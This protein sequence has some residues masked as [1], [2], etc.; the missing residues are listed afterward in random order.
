[1]GEIPEDYMRPRI[2]RLCEN[3]NKDASPAE[4]HVMVGDWLGRIS[5]N[6]VSKAIQG[7]AFVIDKQSHSLEM[8]IAIYLQSLKPPSDLSL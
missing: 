8:E 6:L 2:V 4:E 7:R 5:L 3:V 1:M